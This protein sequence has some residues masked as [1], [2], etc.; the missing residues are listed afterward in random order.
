M[1]VTMLSGK[2]LLHMHLCFMQMSQLA[3]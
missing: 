1:K 2:P 3:C